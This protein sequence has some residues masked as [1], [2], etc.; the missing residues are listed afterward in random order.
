[1]AR[2]EHI[3]WLETFV[4]VVDSG[5]FS[6]A[7]AAVHR[8]QSRVSA[9][10]AALESALGVVLFDRR[11]RPVELTDAGQAYLPHAREALS[12]L[13]RGVNAME[14]VIGVTR[15][16]VVLGSYPS[17]SAAFLPGVMCAF[18]RRYP[19]VQVQLTE[20]PTVRLADAL[21]SGEVDLALRALMPPQRTQG[22]ECRPLWRESLV[23][24]FPPGHAL[25][26]APA[27]ID[28]SALL[29]HPLVTI[30]AQVGQETLFETDLALI[31]VGGSPRVAWQT[32]QPQTLVNF[33]RAGLG[34]GV[35]NAL[36]MHVSDT[37]GLEVRPVG[38]LDAGRVV[39]LF[40]DPHRYL[41]HAA[42]VLRDDILA[43]PIPESTRP[44]VSTSPAH[45]RGRT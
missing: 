20:Q 5:G 4:A 23:A 14:S 3:D 41:P 45:R 15:G 18:S 42:Q 17:A 7:S 13:D 30:G 32:D 33:V 21:N 8:S 24:V 27:P 16:A 35:T 39:G 2:I 9:H 34:V 31:E 38:S 1:M 19:Q 25:A 22:L 44:A 11:H 36:A 10:V 40:W 26:E 43:A 6:A 37:D 28:V 12:A 29:D